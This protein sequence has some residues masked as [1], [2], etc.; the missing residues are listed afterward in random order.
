MGRVL[1]A[2]ACLAWLAIAALFVTL[3][4]VD[5]NLSST[6]TSGV[7]GEVGVVNLTGMEEIASGIFLEREVNS[8]SV[9]LHILTN[10]LNATELSETIE[11]ACCTF[12]GNSAH[13][14]SRNMPLRVYQDE[15]L[16]SLARTT[17]DY[18]ASQTGID[19]LGEI[20]LR[21][22]P[23]TISERT[24]SW[25]EGINVFGYQD[26]GTES[27]LGM[28]TI[29]FKDATLTHI[30]DYAIAL[31]SR[32]SNLCNAANDPDC[33]DKK[34]VVL[35]EALHTFGL[36]DIYDSKCSNK[37]M[38]YQMQAGTTRKRVMD[39]TTKSCVNELYEGFPL[40]G[41]Q[42]PDDL[43]EAN[44][45]ASAKSAPLVIGCFLLVLAGARQW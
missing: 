17:Y 40:D 7:K 5:G 45:G 27:I 9:M 44:R 13:W 31:N 12:L 1:I 3:I 33:H 20:L 28:A 30:T 26:L 43:A 39:F 41:E 34:S 32:V 29:R 42:T 14:Q 19:L 35:H 15:T 10:T 4:F 11:T 36:G 21:N 37:V 25:N 2:C 8:S 6:Q 22:A 16:V 24:A 18:V 38:Y 23:M